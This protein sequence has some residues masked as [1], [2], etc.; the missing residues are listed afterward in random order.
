MGYETLIRRAHVMTRKNTLKSLPTDT[1]FR[2]VGLDLAKSD[3]SVAA[4]PV[5]DNTPSL[6]DRMTYADLLDW[7]GKILRQLCSRWSH[8]TATACC[9]FSLKTLGHEI[10]V[11]SGWTVS[12]WINTHLSGQKTDLNDAIALARLAVSDAELT[13][14]RHKSITEIRIQTV[15]AVRATTYVAALK[16]HCQFQ[17]V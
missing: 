1:E 11:I 4:I 16:E 2:V 17:S 14:I 7:A 9:A 5:D 3:V 10:K 6:V 12:M 15:Q 13:P 8:A